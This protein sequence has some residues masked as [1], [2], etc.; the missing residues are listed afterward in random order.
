MNAA[1]MVWTCAERQAVK[2]QEFNWLA[3]QVGF[4]ASPTMAGGSSQSLWTVYT[5][6]GTVAVLISLKEDRP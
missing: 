2:R 1:P 6:G 5:P 4:G 3:S